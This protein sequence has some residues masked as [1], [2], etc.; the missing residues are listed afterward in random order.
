MEDEDDEHAHENNV[1][2]LELLR[3]GFVAVAAAA[4]WFRVWEPFPRV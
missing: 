3:I 4:V 2:W 1:D